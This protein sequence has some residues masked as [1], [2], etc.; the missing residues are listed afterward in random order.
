VP[1][2]PI[3]G[4]VTRGKGVAI[5]RRDQAL[6]SRLAAQLTDWDEVA[7]VVA[8]VESNRTAP[9]IL[10][11]QYLKL[12]ARCC[13]WNLDPDF[14]NA[15]DCLLVADLMDADA[16]TMLRYGGDDWERVF[17]AHHALEAEAA[18]RRCA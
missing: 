12:A 8:D 4:F 3:A 13:A 5:H 17:R 15:V 16:K 2:D 1:P 9:P 11:K 10:F 6:A 7:E 18:A 14:N